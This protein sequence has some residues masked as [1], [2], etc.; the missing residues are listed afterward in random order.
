MNKIIREMKNKQKRI[1]NEENHQRK[2]KNKRKC[3]K[4][5]EKKQ[6]IKEIGNEEKHQRKEEKQK[7]EMKTIMREMKKKATRNRT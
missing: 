5:L 2:G 6:E 1:G 7:K 4:S 3:I